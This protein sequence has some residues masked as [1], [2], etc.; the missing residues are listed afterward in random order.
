M[1]HNQGFSRV[2]C[3][4][5]PSFP[6]ALIFLCVLFLFLCLFPTSGLAGEVT[7]A[8]DPPSTEYG[9]FILAYGTSS[10][11]YNHTQDVGTQALYTVTSLNPGQTYYFAVKSYNSAR[12]S[13]SPYSNQVMA[14]LSPIDTEPPASPRNVQI[15]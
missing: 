12:D 14:T 6:C 11:N 3:S 2:V 13:E 1:T 9:G 10:G 4:S 5:H 8:W 7:L 15:Q